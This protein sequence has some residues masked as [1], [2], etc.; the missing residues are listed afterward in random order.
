VICLLKAN[1]DNKSEHQHIDSV[2]NCARIRQCHSTRTWRH[3]HCRR[4][5]WHRRS[6]RM[7]ETVILQFFV[8][9]Y[10]FAMLDARRA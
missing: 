7:T 8:V 9:E 4:Q 5:L 6:G 10:F 2:W 1:K 3:R